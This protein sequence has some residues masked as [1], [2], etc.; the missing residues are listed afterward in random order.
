MFDF[1]KRGGEGLL[2]QALIKNIK[3]NPQIL[4]N[5]P[6]FDVVVSDI[7]H[8]IKAGDPKLLKWDDKFKAIVGLYDQVTQGTQKVRKDL[9]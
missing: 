9:N 7:F 6:K 3:S 1:L 8:R 4:T 5:D 2:N